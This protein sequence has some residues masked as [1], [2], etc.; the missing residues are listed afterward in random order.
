MKNKFMDTS[1]DKLARLPTRNPGHGQES[2]TLK[3]K[4]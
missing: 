4:C 3:Q 2:E 1:S